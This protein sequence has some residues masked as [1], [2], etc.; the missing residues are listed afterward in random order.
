MPIGIPKGQY[1][2]ARITNEGGFAY[3]LY[4][5][6][7]SASQKG[8]IVR[9]STAMASSVTVADAGIPDPIGVF[10]EDGVPD[11][12]LAWVVTNGIADVLLEDS[13]AATLR[14]WVKMSE[15]QN[16]R[17]DASIAAPSGGAIGELEEHMHEIGH[18]LESQSAGSD[19]LCRILMHFN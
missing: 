19:V 1:G 6:T 13:T 9:S 10:Y 11:G 15:N 16:G 3:R 18:S 4:N 12:S 5:K 8:L 17:A 7:G 14:Y 2:N